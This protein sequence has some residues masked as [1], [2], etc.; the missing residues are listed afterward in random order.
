MSKTSIWTSDN[1]I[2]LGYCS[3]PPY[4]IKWIKVRI[5][6]FRRQQPLLSPLLSPLPHNRCHFMGKDFQGQERSYFGSLCVWVVEREVSAQ[7]LS[8]LRPGLLV[9]DPK[10]IP[11]VILSAGFLSPHVLPGSPHKPGFLHRP[12]KPIQAKCASE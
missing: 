2:A 6:C 7:S 3:D 12:W 9:A 10:W 4:R 11:S 1:E 5:S 8:V